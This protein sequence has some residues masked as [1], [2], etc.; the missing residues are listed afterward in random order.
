MLGDDYVP[1]ALALAHSLR[2]CGSRAARVV[3]VSSD[4]SAQARA[5]LSVLFDE[6]V[7]VDLLQ[8]RAVHKEWKRFSS[9]AQNGQQ[10]YQWLDK[11]FTK[12][13]VIGL[14][15]Y[16]KVALLDADMLCVS[17]PDELF[18]LRAPAAICSAFKDKDP[19]AHDQWHGRRLSEHQVRQAI[20]TNWGMRGCIN[21]LRPSAAHLSLVRDVLSTY[22]GYGVRRLFIGADEKLLS[23]L[24]LDQWTHVHQRFGLTS[25]KSGPEF[26]GE[27][28]AV[29]LHFV[30]EK[31]WRPAPVDVKNG[32][33]DSAW[34]DYLFFYR[35]AK[36]LVAEQPALRRHFERHIRFMQ[37]YVPQEER[38]QLGD[39]KPAGTTAA[40]DGDKPATQAD[41]QAS[42]AAVA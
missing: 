14:T 10:M 7:P 29:M 40:A 17:N 27:R 22:G 35:T 21:L 23:D 8:G 5:D 33:G 16:D 1:G 18:Q 2:S 37:P 28:P 9:G 36:Q 6:V 30:T 34:P 38:M 41:S 32:S 31:P 11:S 26:T 12:L 20:E 3:L 24:Y 4:V 15:E 25:W 42:A 13:Q 19:A 39:E